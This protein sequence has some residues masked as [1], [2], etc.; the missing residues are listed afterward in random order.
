MREVAG[1]REW[2]RLRAEKEE[3]MFKCGW[4]PLR[5]RQEENGKQTFS[6][7]FIPFCSL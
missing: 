7:Y 1:G 3:E 6:F 2:G 5:N 4:L